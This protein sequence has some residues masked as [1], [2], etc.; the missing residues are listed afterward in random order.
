MPETP[1]TR[2]I[3]VAVIGGGPAGLA[4]ALGAKRA[5]AATVLVLER[6][7]SLGGILNQC[8]HDGFGLFLYKETLSGPEYAERLAEDALR[9][10]VAVE[11][12]AMVLD[13]G[14]DRLLR[15]NARSGYSLVRAG[16]VVLAMGCR[17]RTR[18]MIGIPGTRPAGIY[19]AGSAQHLV[20]LRNLR[21]GNEAVILGSGDIGLI[22]ARRLTLEGVRVKGV[23]EI[24]PWAN[25]LERNVRQCL[26]D[27]GI[28][29]RLRSTVVDVRGRDRVESVVVAEVDDR[30][31]PVPGSETVVPCDTLLLSVGLIPENELSK[32]AGVE[33][34]PVTGGAVVDET[35][36]TSVPG[37]FSCGNVLHIHDVA[38][39]ASFEG[40]AAGERAVRYAA[41]ERPSG[42]TVRIAA[43]AEVRYALPQTVRAGAAGVEWSFRVVRPLRDVRVEV[44]GRD[45]GKTYARRK[46]GRLLPSELQKIK[47]KAEVDEDLEVGVHV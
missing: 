29:L 34:S 23:Y 33:L 38:D 43:G 22:M 10:G 26:M 19:T 36:M 9:E 3:D 31:V 35:L 14:P 17:E 6:D 28:P 24:M 47:V 40:F 30:M 46:F 42:R 39:W 5:G 21:V 16:A 2:D 44:R 32:R 18:D 4:A 27:F 45:S 25:G 7:R 20:N 11:T 8:V 15:V 12:G 41:G 1:R 13:L 37:V